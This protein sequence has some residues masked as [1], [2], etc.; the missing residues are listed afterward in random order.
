MPMTRLRVMKDIWLI[1]FVRKNC[2]DRCKLLYMLGL[3]I[4][5]IRGLGNEELDM[6]RIEPPAI[7]WFFIYA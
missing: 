6:D 4:R 2:Q 1:S 5:I 3:S 7:W